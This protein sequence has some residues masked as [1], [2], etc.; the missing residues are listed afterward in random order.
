MWAAYTNGIGVFGSGRLADRFG[1]GPVLAGNALVWGFVML[2]AIGP[3][4]RYWAVVGA[5][6]PR[7][8]RWERVLAERAASVRAAP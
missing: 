1:L 3:L 8:R 6:D 4:R 5:G 7:S 2:I